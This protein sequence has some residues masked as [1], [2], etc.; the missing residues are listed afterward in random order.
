MEVGKSRDH[1]AAMKQVTGEAQYTDDIPPQHGELYAGIVFSKHAHARIKSIDP[2]QALCLPGVHA[3]IGREQ[4]QGSNVI[5]PVFKDEQVFPE[6]RVEYAGQI[7]ALVLAS[8]QRQAQQ[9]ARQVRVEYEQL[10]AILTIEQAIEAQSFH[11][12]LVKMERGQVD[13]AFKQSD[14]HVLE[15]EIR[16]GGQ[17]H[18]YLETQAALI[19][20]K[21]EDDEIEVWAST[22][23]PTETQHL[24]ASVLG[25]ADSKVVCRVK[26]LGGG[27][28]GKET[29]SAPLTCAL[30]VAA[31][32][33]MRPVRCMLDRDEDM[34]YS[35]QRHPFLGRYKVGFDA[36]GRVQALDV[37][38]YANAGHSA[39]LS[40][41]VVERAVSHSDNCYYIPNIRV[42]GRAC[43]TNI[44][45]NTAFRGF[46]GPQGMLI[47][48]TWISHVSEY[49]RV[50]AE[51]IRELNLYTKG[52]LT[53]FNQ[54]LEDFHVPQ[55]WH[56]I[57]D[58]CQLELRRKEIEA[59]NNANVWRKRG[60]A[61]IPTKYARVLLF[62][63]CQ[64]N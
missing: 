46:G 43:K 62:D 35:G 29:R 1:L 45:S 8:T 51:R 10:P 37:Q 26:R 4:V 27:F 36:S 38:L 53:H 58:T 56:S 12:R 41:A 9:A 15:G 61:A 23:N 20:P 34:A 49:L 48:E 18:F 47:A 40:V 59:F 60:I 3:F 31:K 25:I 14:I 44:H 22:Q 24:V 2:S 5:G 54:P 16:I 19:V 7:I 11:S 64:S 32:H 52:Q 55:L 63:T 33:C 21:R 6:D 30:A 13:E 50:P 42:T 28:G 39:D 57:L 17:E